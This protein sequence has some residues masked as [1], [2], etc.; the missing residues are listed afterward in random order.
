M[1]GPHETFVRPWIPLPARAWSLIQ[2]TDANILYMIRWS[3]LMGFPTFVFLF[4]ARIYCLIQYQN[5]A[6]AVLER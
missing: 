4:N 3:N 1:A 5:R 2:G 6:T